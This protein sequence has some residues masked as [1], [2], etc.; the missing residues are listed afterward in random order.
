MYKRIKLLRASYFNYLWLRGPTGG[1][2]A[3]SCLKPPVIR[4]AKS[5]L[6]LLLV[7]RRSFISLLQR[8]WERVVIVISSVALHTSVTHA[9]E[10]N[11]KY[12]V[13]LLVNTGYC[14]SRISWFSS[15][16]D[17]MWIKTITEVTA[18]SCHIPPIPSFLSLINASYMML[19]NFCCLYSVQINIFV[20]SSVINTCLKQIISIRCPA[21][22]CQW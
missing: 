12:P 9:T 21:L 3:T 4:T 2:H 11:I 16:L 6:D 8:I 18:A 5:F 1:P 19:H 22:S 20:G 14:Y 10:F 15:V 17:W 7:S 13:Q